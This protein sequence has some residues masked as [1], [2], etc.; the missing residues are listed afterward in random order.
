[1]NSSINQDIIIDYSNENTNIYGKFIFDENDKNNKFIEI[2]E[3]EEIDTTNIKENDIIT[4]K[5]LP[6]NGTNIIEKYYTAGNNLEF[7]KNK[8]FIKN[9]KLDLEDYHNNYNFK[10]DNFTIHFR[11]LSISFKDIN[12]E[13]DAANKETNNG[14]IKYFNTD[15]SANKQDNIHNKINPISDQ[16]AKIG[17]DYIIYNNSNFL[18]E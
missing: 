1:M 7:N 3:T 9:N 6:N 4:F 11:Y 10:D 13:Y 18:Q 14:G 16:S 12:S 17:N 8:L 15:R 2:L 5:F